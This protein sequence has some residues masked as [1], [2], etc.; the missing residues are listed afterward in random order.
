MALF[1]SPV[2]TNP[3]TKSGLNFLFITTR[4]IDCTGLTSG[5]KG[6]SLVECKFRLV[7]LTIIPRPSGTAR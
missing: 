4:F 1:G 5:N 7:Y 6:M 3:G 2:R